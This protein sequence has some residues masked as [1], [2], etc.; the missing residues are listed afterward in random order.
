M[1][2]VL[3]WSHQ[4]KLKA[5]EIYSLELNSV[6]KPGDSI[7][8]L[9]RNHIFAAGFKPAGAPGAYAFGIWYAAITDNST[10]VW[11]ANRDRLVDTNSS[12]ALT[13]E[14]NMVLSTSDVTIVWATNTSD[15]GVKK[16]VLQENGSLALLSASRGGSSVWQSFDHPTD[17][18]L[19]MQ[20]FLRDVALVSKKSENTYSSG[21]YK[22]SFNRD[23]RLSLTYTGEAVAAPPAEY[24]VDLDSMDQSQQYAVTGGGGELIIANAGMNTTGGIIISDG[25]TFMSSDL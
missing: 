16:A 5:A 15:K 13:Q 17:T 25:I 2:S 23:N 19:P 1:L 4:L 21:D 24:W 6:L 3:I 12:M 7:S 14:G 10:V 18:L 9:S 22:L 8:L 20:R 11:L